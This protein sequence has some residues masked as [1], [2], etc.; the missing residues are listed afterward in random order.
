MFGSASRR[1][2]SPHAP[3]PSPNTIATALV[4]LA[5]LDAHEA[6]GD[7]HLL[8]LAAGAGEF[9]LARVQQTD[10]PGGAYFGY[11][12]NDRTPIHNANL[13]AAALLAA[14]GQRADRRDF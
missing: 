13:L 6:L 3:R 10:A 9:F 8:E 12:P 2:T 5:L 7:L 11:L 14:A 4:G 1:T